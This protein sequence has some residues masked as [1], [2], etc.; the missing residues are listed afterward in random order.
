[1]KESVRKPFKIIAGGQTGVD[2]AALEFARDHGFPYG[3]WV[4]R[5]RTNEAGE[6]PSDFLGLKETHSTDVIERT[7]LNVE[8]GDATLIFVDGSKSP[9][10]DQTVVFAKE[11]NKPCCVVDV[12]AGLDACAEQI[13]AWLAT[14]N[15]GVLNIAGPRYSE[16][17][18]LG[19]LVTRI[20]ER[21]L[22][23]SEP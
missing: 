22:T 21:T 15:V 4:P 2:L 17:P 12:S 8:S 16:A 20:L 19:P 11:M 14:T 7:R 5:G 1:M 6:I 10:T 13:G 3:G 18:D 23:H 9:G